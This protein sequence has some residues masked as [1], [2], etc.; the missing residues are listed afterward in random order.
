MMIAFITKSSLPLIEDLCSSDSI[1]IQVL[2]FT[3][4][5][6]LCFFGKTSST[7]KHVVQISSLLSAYTYT[8]V[9]S[10]YIRIDIC[11]DLVHLTSS[12]PDPWAHIEY[13]MCSVCVCVRIHTHTHTYAPT[14]SEPDRDTCMCD[15]SNPKSIMQTLDLQTVT[16]A[17]VTALASRASCRR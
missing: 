15:C 1:S 13:P 6:L 10:T 4:H 7:K 8:C 9:L 17:C 11:R 2:G 16:L 5:L 14:M 3:F 12:G